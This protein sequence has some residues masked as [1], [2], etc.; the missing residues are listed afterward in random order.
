M[1]LDNAELPFVNTPGYSDQ[2]SCAQSCEN[3]LGFNGCSTSKCWC[4][5]ENFVPGGEQSMAACLPSVCS[6]S[7]VAAAE[8]LAASVFSAYCTSKGFTNL[9][10]VTAA[11]SSSSAS[12]STETSVNISRLTFAANSR[13]SSSAT[14]TS[15]NSISPTSA[16]SGVSSSPP[17]PHKSGL[18][19]GASGAIG[20]VAVVLV[21]GIAAALYIFMRRR[22]Q[23]AA[24]RPDYPR[25]DVRLGPH[26]LE[27]KDIPVKDAQVHKFSAKPS[28]GLPADDLSQE[29]KTAMHELA[30]EESQIQAVS[31]QSVHSPSDQLSQQTRLAAQELDPRDTQVHEAFVQPG[32]LG[33]GPAQRWE[34]DG[35]TR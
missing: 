1:S 35:N 34:L 10:Q 28:E 4:S 8:T 32:E 13:S 3:F 12:S 31:P 23:K 24:T 29:K 26:E 5:P 19:S 33:E 9:A 15:G 20:A 30:P 7:Q 17:P 16:S 22:K 6:S 18:S 27:P 25:E 21:L 11:P 14:T 2:L